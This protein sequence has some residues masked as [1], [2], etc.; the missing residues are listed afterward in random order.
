MGP[1]GKKLYQSFSDE[2]LLDI[3]RR[4]AALFDE[5]IVLVAE[6]KDK[7][8]FFTPQERMEISSAE[9]MRELLRALVENIRK[10]KRS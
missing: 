6:N 8:G 9:E 1:T 4:A 7:H 3:I 10:V 2:D 5:V